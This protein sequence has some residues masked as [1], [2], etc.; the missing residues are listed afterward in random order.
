MGGTVAGPHGPV[1]VRRYAARRETNTGTT[2]VWLH[3]GGFF[4][5]TLDLPEAHVVAG[6]LADRGLDVVTV[7]YRLAPLPGL[8]AVGRRGSHSRRHHP[9]PNDDVRA[10]LEVVRRQTDGPVLL[11]GASA[12]ACLAAAVT[13]ALPV[14]ARPSG[15][16]LAYGF[17]HARSPRDPAVLRTVRGHRRLTHHPTLLDRANRNHVGRGG[18]TVA[19]F[20]GGQ[21]L[22]DF[23]RTLMVDAERDTMRASGDRFAD[24]LRGAGAEI[25]RHV[26]PGAR[27]A[28]LNR[29]GSPD[30]DRALD[31]VADWTAGS[32]RV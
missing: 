19:A 23:P 15:L 25:E 32:S 12:G 29:P 7:G 11:G 30:S 26:L 18:D 5:G 22:A 9:V 2:L 10:V 14:A 6:A 1:P 3:G 4:R 21:D 17:F 13:R 28:F 24:E 27:H 20:P 31:L 16:V 8:P